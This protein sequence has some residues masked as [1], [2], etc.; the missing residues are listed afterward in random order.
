MFVR[1]FYSAVDPADADEV[2]RI[3]MEDIKPAF[4]EVGCESVELLVNIEANAGGLVEGVVISR[5]KTTAA[6]DE[7]LGSRAVAESLVRVR[8]LL[9]QEP[10]T[11]TFE[12]RE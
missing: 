3:F 12:V 5:W 4:E 2:Q 8:E 10:V 6:M 11:R 1:F 9:R 7:A